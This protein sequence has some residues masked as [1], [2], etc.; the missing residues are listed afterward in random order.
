M[1]TPTWGRQKYFCTQASV[2]L[3]SALA[4]VPPEQ[5]A[6]LWGHSSGGRGKEQQKEEDAG[7]SVQ[8]Q[9][10]REGKYDMFVCFFVFNKQD[11][12]ITL[13]LNSRQ[14]VK[15]KDEVYIHELFYLPKDLRFCP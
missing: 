7:C 3:G 2:T 6:G 9:L 15:C 10:H 14:E 1:T 11:F 12:T 8:N 13:K 5:A 4:R